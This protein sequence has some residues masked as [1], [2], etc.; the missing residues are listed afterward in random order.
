LVLD[1]CWSCWLVGQLCSLSLSRVSV[2]LFSSALCHCSVTVTRYTRQS[3]YKYEAMKISTSLLFILHPTAP[4][5]YPLHYYANPPA[6]KPVSPHLST[7]DPASSVYQR[8]YDQSSPISSPHVGVCCLH[9]YTLPSVPEG[10]ARPSIF[11]HFLQ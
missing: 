3:I 8:K 1:G 9:F 6:T 2:F 5:T 7:P 10:H 4:T 11:S